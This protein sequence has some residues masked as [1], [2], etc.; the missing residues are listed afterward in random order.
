VGIIALQAYRRKALLAAARNGT[1]ELPPPAEP[2]RT[3]RAKKFFTCDLLDA[4]E[5]FIDEG[6]DL[7]PLLP[8]IAALK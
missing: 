5:G 8:E 2:H 1:V 4:W 7:P 6:V 3:G